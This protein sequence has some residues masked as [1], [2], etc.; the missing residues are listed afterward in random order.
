MDAWEYALGIFEV[1]ETL[2]S[3]MF[4]HMLEQILP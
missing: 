3:A 1:E 4:E 2:Q